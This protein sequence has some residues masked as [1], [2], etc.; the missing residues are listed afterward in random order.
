MNR[1]SGC[2]AS[3]EADI[4]RTVRA[5]V[6]DLEGSFAFPSLLVAEGLRRVVVVGRQ[7]VGAV[8]DVRLLVTASLLRAVVSPSLPSEAGGSELDFP[9]T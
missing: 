8:F 9:G 4:D 6:E 2:F 3:A 1:F 7:E 5:K